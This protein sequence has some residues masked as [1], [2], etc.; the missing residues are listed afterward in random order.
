VRIE[1]FIPKTPVETL[2]EC[3]LHRLAGF[4]VMEFDPMLD[5]PAQEV[6]TR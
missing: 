3:V 1:A 6:A 5:S 4:N 2:D